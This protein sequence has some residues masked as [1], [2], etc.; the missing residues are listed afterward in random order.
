MF[1]SRFSRGA[2]FLLVAFITILA[3]GDFPL[4]A[5]ITASSCQQSAVS[6]AISSANPGDV[7]QV[8]AGSCS[9][10]GLNINKAIHLRGAGTG[11]TR[12]TLSAGNSV[13][14]QSSGVTRIS[15]FGFSKSGGGNASQ[16]FYINGPWPSGDPVIFH[17]NSF[18][19]SNSG[20]FRVQ[21]PGGVIFA[22]NSFSG[23]WDD[24]FLQLK[25]EDMG[26]WSTADTIGTADTN[27]KRNIYIETNSFV[28]GTNQGIDADDGARVVVRYNTFDRSSVN[29]H[30]LDTS[31]VG[32]RHWEVYNNKFTHPGG[33]CT[34]QLCNQSWFILMRGA[35]G[36]ITEN[37]FTDIAGG[38]WGGKPEI[39]FWIRGAEDVRPQGS[40]SSVRY[41]VPRQVGQN[42]NGS[43]YFTDPIRIWNNSG[44]QEVYADWHFG[45]P[46]GLRFSDFWQSGRD[47][48]TSARPGYAKYAYP[49]PL[50]SGS[51]TPPPPAP[52]A[53]TQV[54]VLR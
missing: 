4:A 54:R 2:G 8:P 17:D 10:S 22:N 13:T 31:P 9:W 6:A 32:V 43:S 52:A 26:S 39:A 40:C 7:V 37:S 25:G 42:H 45:N 16:A 1:L 12:I 19:I 18:T 41:P 14:K 35:T 3:S 20:L 21:V 24:S 29:S 27:G 34:T 23:E 48:A 51:T 11:Q 15:G 38:Y 33:S 50:L 44:A 49:H 47:Y 5:T 28:G 36:V 53:P 30:G 46:C